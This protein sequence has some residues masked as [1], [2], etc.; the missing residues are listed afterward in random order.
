MLL[1]ED[2]QDGT[3]EELEEIL[4]RP[5]ADVIAEC[6]RTVIGQDTAVEEVVDLI[7]A[8]LQRMRMRAEGTDE[9]D[10]PRACAF[11]LMGTTASGKSFIMKVVSHVM[12]LKLVTIDCTGI[13]GAGWAGDSVSSELR[14][15]AHEL[16]G[17]GPA[18]VLAFWDEADK[19]V[20][21][22]KG[23]MRGFDA[24]SN[25]LKLLDGGRMVLE[26]EQPGQHE[27]ELDTSRVLNVFA[28]AFMGIEDIVR[29]RLLSQKVSVAGTRMVPGLLDA[30]DLYAKAGLEDLISWGFMPELVGRFGAVVSVPALSVASL[31]KI[32]KGTPRSLECRVSNLLGPARSFAID[33]A[34]AS[35]IAHEAAASGL[36]ARRIDQM[37]NRFAAEALARLQVPEKENRA[38]LGVGADGRLALS[39]DRTELPKDAA[40]EDLPDA[41]LDA[42]AAPAAG[43]AAPGRA[44]SRFAP[45]GR[46]MH[47]VDAAVAG[48]RWSDAVASREGIELMS[49]RLAR[50]ERWHLQDAR[51]VRAAELLI[52]AVTGYLSLGHRGEMSLGETCAYIRFSDIALKDGASY[53]DVLF[54]G[55]VETSGIRGLEERA[56]NDPAVATPDTV[57]ALSAYRRY[58]AEPASVRKEAARLATAR[59]LAATRSEDEAAWLRS[60]INGVA[61]ALDR[62]MPSFKG[63]PLIF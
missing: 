23:E 12:G 46:L 53:L 34:A 45:D 38:I 40:A 20:R 21:S 48:A 25:L 43:E 7:Y 51:S 31:E 16:D 9:L 15:V 56:E 10:L 39:F 37:A 6:E 59:A 57:A 47:A 41:Q 61:L 1:G 42:A 33:D 49:S 5:R 63:M 36:G 58:L 17:A 29:R 18:P 3:A 54:F 13:T 2:A 50:Y 8:C 32:V 44:K 60:D 27:I 52:S 14:R 62:D 4:A 22:Q 19:L 26:P 28:G 30:K 11:M 35:L 24:Q 55:R